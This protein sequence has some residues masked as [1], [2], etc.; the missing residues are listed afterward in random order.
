MNIATK[1]REARNKKLATV[2]TTGLTVAGG[3]IGTFAAP[4]L[5]TA[6]G[7][8]LGAG[9]GQGAA[10]LLWGEGPEVGVT[11]TALAALAGSRRSRLSELQGKLSDF[12]SSLDAVGMGG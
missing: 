5:G 1:E 4:G 9:L 12:S 7:A 8:A 2:L 3:V 6:G 11:E 10:A